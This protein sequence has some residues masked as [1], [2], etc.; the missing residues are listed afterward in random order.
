MA[1]LLLLVGMAL[2][3]AGYE[4]TLRGLLAGRGEIREA[5]REIK[6]YLDSG[7]RVLVEAYIP[8]PAGHPNLIVGGHLSVTPEF[9]ERTDPDIL[10]FNKKQ[11]LNILRDKVPDPYILAGR[12]NYHEIRGFYGSF[13]EKNHD[14]LLNQIKWNK[15]KD[16]GIFIYWQKW[17]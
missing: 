16:S 2:W 15:F 8:Y 13:F 11:V 6:S 12:E 14:I 17:K 4:A 5:Y 9:V 1:G 7:K 10:V 3:P